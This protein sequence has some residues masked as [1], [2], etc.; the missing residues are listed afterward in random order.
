MG[1]VV[2]MNMIPK[3]IHYEK[4]KKN[5]KDPILST[6]YCYYCKINFENKIKY[7]EHLQNCINTNS[8]LNQKY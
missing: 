7:N 3:I 8:Y 5:I 4:E 6:K 2:S 1:N